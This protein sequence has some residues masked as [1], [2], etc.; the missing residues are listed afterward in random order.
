[1]TGDTYDD[2]YHAAVHD[3][4]QNHKSFIHPFDDDM[5]IAGQGTVGLEILEDHTEPIDYLFVPVGG[6]GLTAGLCQVFS[7]LSPKTKIIGLEPEGAPSM[8]EALKAGEP[9]SLSHI[10]KFVDG[11]A[12]KR[13]GD[14]TFMAIN[15]SLHAMQ[16]IPEGKVC[17]VILKLYNEEAMVVEP[18]AALSIAALD[19][20][21][22][23]IKG[24][25]VVCIISG[26]NNDIERTEE[27][28]EKSLIFEGLKHYFMVQFPQRPGALREFVTH[29]LS[30]NDDITY[31][32]FAKRNS[33][34]Y[35]P[36]IVGLELKDPGQ[37]YVIKS[38]MEKGGYTY[39][40]LNKDEAMLAHFV[41]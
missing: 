15:G 27:I 29:V 8:T 25:N 20:Y 2:A 18:A 34:E 12:V 19:Y 30:E 35:A 28:K 16:L 7:Q 14:R 24:K 5:I 38:R 13:V 17:T 32:Q 33:R 36:A 23:E 37:V 31:F 10:D 4:D 6:G 26:S 40:Y 41:G 11:A 9:V 3:A 1:L 39:E 21:Q 22:E